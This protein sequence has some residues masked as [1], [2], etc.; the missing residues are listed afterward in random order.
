MRQL[1]TE[2]VVLSLLDA[3]LGTML[4][5]LA[6][7]VTLPLV[8]QFSLPGVGG[9][10]IDARVM[11]FCLALSLAST[12]LIGLVPALRVSGTELDSKEFAV[13]ARGCVD[14]EVAPG[15]RCTLVVSFTP[16]WTGDRVADLTVH[17]NVPGPAAFVELTGRG[18]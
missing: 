5:Q 7:S 18:G 1:L 3:T 6:V 4:A 10:V 8:P 9:I 17:H 16:E 13:D 11:A 12:L 2:A 15:K 14:V